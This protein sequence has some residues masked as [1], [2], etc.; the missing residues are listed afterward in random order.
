M[1][2]F[3]ALQ[4]FGEVSAEHRRA[5]GLEDHH[6]DAVAQSRLQHLQGAAGDMLG[7]VELTGRDPRQ[8]TAHRLFRH[9]HLEPGIF[10]H[11]QRGAGNIGVEVVGEGV[12]PQ[13]DGA[14]GG[15]LR[16]VTAAREPR[17]EPS[18][19]EPGNVAVA[20]D[21]SGALEQRL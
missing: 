15:G 4:Q 17:R 2:V 10:E 20:V 5:A 6:R 8:P 21:T 16:P 18:A 11:G 14:A 19:G 9:P 12:R 1:H 7:G 3:V 13:H